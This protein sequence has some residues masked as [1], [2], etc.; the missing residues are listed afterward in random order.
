MKI[1]KRIVLGLVLVLVVLLLAVNFFGG[2]IIRTG[3]NSAGPALLKV[4]VSLDGADLKL[5]RGTLA[6]KGL[7]VGNPEGFKSP[8]LLTLG[9]LQVELE[10]R[11]L[12]SGTIVIDKVYLNAPEITFEKSLTGSNISALL[13]KLGGEKK[14]G[15]ETPKK[16][17]PAA[18]SAGGKKVVIN[19]FIIENGKVHLALSAL[20][21]HGATLPLP[22]LHLK[23]IGKEKGGASWPEVIGRVFT[24]IAHAVTGVVTGAGEL[25]GEGAKAVGD[26][27]V[28]GVSAAGEA[29][30][31][32]GKALGQG[33]AKIAEGVGSLFGERKKDAK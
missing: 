9:D 6:L 29:V 17:E 13:D 32:A 20:G 22:T 8:H 24:E 25:V 28:K 11:S 19:D 30:G 10:P 7:A 14:E 5:L 33:A 26:T 23:D 1:L 3:V 12:A 21:G 16:E 18:E 15:G 31:D 4:P 2:R 27:A